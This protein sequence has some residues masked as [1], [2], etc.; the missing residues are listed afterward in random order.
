M[1]E[2]VQCNLRYKYDQF[3]LFIETFS[4]YYSQLSTDEAEKKEEKR[5][6]TSEEPE[7]EMPNIKTYAH[8]QSKHVWVYVEKG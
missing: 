2:H 4:S 8:E 3:L 5:H 1:D 7:R 6:R